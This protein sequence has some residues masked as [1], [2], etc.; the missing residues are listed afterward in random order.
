MD[1]INYNFSVLGA[2]PCMW[3][4]IAWYSGRNFTK[5]VLRPLATKNNKLFQ[6]CILLLSFRLPCF[7]LHD[8][9]PPFLYTTQSICIAALPFLA[10]W[11]EK[12]CSESNILTMDH[13]LV[14]KNSSSAP[15]FTLQ[16][17]I[18]YLKAVKYWVSDW[19]IYVKQTRA[20]D[21]RVGKIKDRML[22]YGC[23]NSELFCWKL[24]TLW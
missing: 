22:C 23:K 12:R 5:L 7:S 10:N 3:D 14:L 1:F 13:E 2:H 9:Y 20:S 15:V 16:N 17:N 21:L 6:S 24:K 8:D 18:T 19:G 4:I 11:I